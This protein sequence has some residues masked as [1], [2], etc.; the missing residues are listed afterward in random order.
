MSRTTRKEQ[1]L[2]DLIIVISL[3]RHLGQEWQKPWLKLLIKKK[4]QNHLKWYCRVTSRVSLP[5]ENKIKI[6]G[7][8]KETVFFFVFFFLSWK[9]RHIRATNNPGQGSNSPT[10]WQSQPRTASTVRW[11]SEFC[12]DLL[13]YICILSVKVVPYLIPSI[14]YYSP[15]RRKNGSNGQVIEI[16]LSQNKK[17]TWTPKY[18]QGWVSITWSPADYNF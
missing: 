2:C 14:Y 17:V 18:C 12:Q 16:Y 7:H 3:S 9:F 10:P 11:I 4:K 15:L 5:F 8:I 13:G 6:A 1:Y